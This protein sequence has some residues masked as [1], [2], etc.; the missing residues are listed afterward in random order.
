ME[1]VNKSSDAQW[2]AFAD[3]RLSPEDECRVFQ[4][5]CNQWHGADMS[6]ECSHQARTLCMY[7]FAS[8]QWLQTQAIVMASKD[9]LVI[10]AR[11]KGSPFRVNDS[12]WTGII[13]QTERSTNTEILFGNAR[14][15]R[16]MFEKTA[17]IMNI[18]RTDHEGAFMAKDERFLVQLISYADNDEDFAH[19]AY[20][21]LVDYGIEA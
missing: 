6:L 15:L 21:P 11:R 16:A 3:A 9:P 18:T 7:H 17:A 8:M 12:V 13:M 19:R 5:F 1:E 4:S 2:K 14:K 20:T 10:M